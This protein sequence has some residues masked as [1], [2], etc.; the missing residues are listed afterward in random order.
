MRQIKTGGQGGKRLKKG[1]RKV[2]KEPERNRKGAG[3]EPER[4]R[5]KDFFKKIQTGSKWLS[6]SRQL[7]NV[8]RA[9]RDATACLYWLHSDTTTHGERKRFSK[10]QK[11]N[12]TTASGL[13][14][15]PSGCRQLS[16]PGKRAKGDDRIRL[17]AP[18]GIGMR[19]LLKRVNRSPPLAGPSAEKRF[20]KTS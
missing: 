15:R 13:H 2:Q 19:H 7:K 3:K 10:K 8:G 18:S 6:E 12:G 14:K 20:T 16:F 17:R 1:S 11:K 9:E 4:S 5:M